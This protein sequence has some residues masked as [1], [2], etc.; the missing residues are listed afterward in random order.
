MENNVFS[1]GSRV[2]VTSYGPFRGLR[3]TIQVVNTLS[4]DIEKP[5]RFYL[6]ALDGTYLPDSVWFEYDEV[7]LI[8]STFVAL[9]QGEVFETVS[10][11]GV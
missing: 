4:D 10:R 3:G 11:A 7:E 2:Y 6:I 5:F 8:S 9:P 1:V